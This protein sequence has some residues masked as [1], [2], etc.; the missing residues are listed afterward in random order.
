MGGIPELAPLEDAQEDDE[1][2]AYDSLISKLQ[3]QLRSERDPDYANHL[4]VSN[5]TGH[6]DQA[7][8]EVND[9]VRY[10]N[11]V[12]LKVKKG[13]K[14]VAENVIASATK[15]FVDRSMGIEPEEPSK[16]TKE[17]RQMIRRTC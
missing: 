10:F 7:E 11:S 8:N 15:G 9:T 16:K 14:R 4:P 13:D 1:M 17:E 5:H 12:A 3:S 2:D 6:S